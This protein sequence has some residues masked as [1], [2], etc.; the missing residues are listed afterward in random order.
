MQN[1]EIVVYC[2]LQKPGA[3][4]QETNTICKHLKAF[5]SLE[6]GNRKKT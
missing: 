3:M 6:L 2:L 4:Q 1:P 5:P